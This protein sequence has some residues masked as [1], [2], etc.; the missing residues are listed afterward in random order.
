MLPGF[1]DF[2]KQHWVVGGIIASLLWFFAGR[3]SLNNGRPDFA[4]FWQSV[5]ALI[6]LALCGWAIATREW[7]GFVVGATVLGFELRSLI[8]TPSTKEHDR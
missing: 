4:I 1:T 5:G 2:L 6:A 8:R 7:L 3:Q